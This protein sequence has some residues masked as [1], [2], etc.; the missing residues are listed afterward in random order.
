MLQIS[1]PCQLTNLLQKLL[2]FLIS[3]SFPVFGFTLSLSFN[4]SQ[5]FISRLHFCAKFIGLQLIWIV[6]FFKRHLMWLYR[7]DFVYILLQPSLRLFG[8]IIPI[9]RHLLRVVWV[10]FK[11]IFIHKFL[12]WLGLH[13]YDFVLLA[14]T[15]FTAI[16]RSVLIYLNLGFFVDLVLLLYFV[17][18]LLFFCLEDTKLLGLP[19]DLTEW[20]SYSGSLRPFL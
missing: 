9:L 13:K 20:H 3:D 1:L 6:S 14:S 5:F 8:S 2:S 11:S 15:S 4:L 16:I 19:A 10:V 7:N 18:Q 12:T 17:F